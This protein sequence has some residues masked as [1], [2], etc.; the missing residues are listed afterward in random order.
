L[1]SGLTIFIDNLEIQKR[2]NQPREVSTVPRDIARSE[3]VDQEQTKLEESIIRNKNKNPLKASRVIRS[4]PTGT[5]QK[6]SRRE[7]KRIA[8]AKRNYKVLI[9]S[10]AVLVPTGIISVPP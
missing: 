5:I 1:D 7:K 10:M 2:A 8:K 4:N 9:G 6:L 3:S